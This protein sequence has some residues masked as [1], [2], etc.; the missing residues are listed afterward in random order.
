M[1]KGHDP[2][3]TVVAYCTNCG[4]I[5][6]SQIPMIFGL[7]NVKNLNLRGNYEEC[8]N[9]HHMARTV[10]GVFEILQGVARLLQGPQITTEIL[11]Q[12][13]KLVQKARVGEITP[14]ELEREAARLDPEL[15]R[16]VTQAR[17]SGLSFLTAILLISIAAIHSCKLDAKIDLNKAIDQAITIAEIIIPTKSMPADNRERAGDEKKNDPTST[18]SIPGKK[19]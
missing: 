11:A 3:A 15:G 12:F 18:G 1:P 10:D 6:P 16:A 13:E 5:F 4:T 17:T 9:C 2:M 7:R 8:P 19:D 14:D